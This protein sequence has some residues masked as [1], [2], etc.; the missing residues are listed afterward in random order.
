MGVNLRVLDRAAAML[1]T[2]NTRT[3]ATPGDVAR[4]IEPKTIQ[5]PALDILDGALVAAVRGTG[6]K[7]VIITCPPQEGK[8]VRCSRFFPIWALLHDR[9]LRIA[10][11]GYQDAISRRWGRRVR[12]DVNDYPDLGLVVSNTSG[13]ANEWQLEGSGGG[14]ITS[15]VTGSLTGRPVD[16]MIIDDPHKDQGEADSETIRNTIK[17]W[18]RTVGSTRLSPAGVVILVQTRWHEDDLAGFLTNEENEGHDEWHVIN[19][20]AQAEHDP[21]KGIECK[22]N[23]RKGCLGYDVLGR[24]PGEFMESA[25]GRDTANWLQRKRDAGSRGWAALYQGHPAPSDGNI[26]KRDWWQYYDTPRAVPQG[27]GSMYVPGTV[28]VEIHVDATFKD[29]KHSDFVVMQVWA[30]D[31][32]KAWLLDQVRA[33]MDFTVTVTTLEQLAAKWPQARAKVVEDK[34][35]GPAI[36]S[37]LRKKVSGVIAYTPKDSKEARA[38]A[39]APYVEAGDVLLPAAKLAPWVGAFVDECAAFP[40]GAHDDQV[41]GMSQALHRLLAKGRPQIRTT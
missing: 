41:D 9:D 40:N 27:D 36:I 34:A 3:Y 25:R 19:I 37:M 2:T 22:C 13:A 18:W 21:D 28:T 20:Q 11:I 29:T 31:G 12:D 14:M 30:S 24:E 1:G 4:H 8:S 39:I 32:V 15:S 35:N 17:D 26:F 5:T 16:L 10:N 38:S 33:R 6:P 23:G 7:R